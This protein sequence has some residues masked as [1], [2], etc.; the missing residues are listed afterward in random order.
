MDIVDP[1]IERY[2]SGLAA[3]DDHPVLTE[4]EEHARDQDFPI[5]GRLCGRLLELMARSV[6]AQRVFEM[7]SGF[8]YSAYWFSRAVGERGEIHLTDLDANNERKALDYLGRADLARPI[9]YYVA[10]AFDALDDTQGEFDVVYCDIDK[11]DYP[12]AWNRAKQRVRPG[13]LY[14]CDNMLWFGRVTGE[15]SDDTPEMTEAIDATNRMISSDPDWRSTIVPLRDG[16]MVAV[17]IG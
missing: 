7:G 14:M 11:A 3:A 6:Q 9:Q 17:R 4:M 12:E 8:G 2:L 5:V 1:A 15:V 10:S 16:V 13:G